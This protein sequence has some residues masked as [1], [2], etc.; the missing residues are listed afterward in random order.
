[1]AIIDLGTGEADKAKAAPVRG[2]VIDLESGDFA[3]PEAQGETFEQRAARLGAQ[4]GIALTP[5]QLGAI[6]RDETIDPAAPTLPSGRDFQPRQS[7]GEESGFGRGVEQGLLNIG[8]GILRG[9]GEI[10]AQLGDEGADQFLADLMQ[11]QSLERTQTE[12]ETADSPI[13]SFAGEVTGEIL[14]FPFGGAGGSLPTRLLSAAAAGGA[15]GALSAGGRGESGVDIA[16]EAAISGAIA[17]AA[18]GVSALLGARQAARQADVVGGVGADREAIESAA[19]S[20]ATGQRAAQETGIGLLP[21]QKTLDPFQAEVQ[22]FLGQNPEVSRKAFDTLKTQNREASEAVGSLLDAIAL[23]SSPATAPGRA[24]RAA[25]N[26]ID[27]VSAIRA[28]KASPIYKEAFA[29]GA[30]VDLLPVNNVIDDIISTL[31]EEGSAIKRKVLRAQ[32]LISGDPN[33]KQLHS[34]KLE[35]DEMLNAKGEGAVGSTT[36]RHLT[37]IQDTLVNEMNIASSLYDQAR[38]EFKR[39]SPAVDEIRDGVF[40]RIEALQDKDLKRV[41]S[42]IFD[43]TESNPEIAT[44]AIK[45]L[46][47]VEGGDEIVGGLIRTEIEKRLGRM[48][49]DLAEA[50]DTGGRK[51]ENLPQQLLNNVYGNAKQR[52]ML[53]SALKEV[54][55]KAAN[56]AKW[57]EEGLTRASVGRPGG[58]QT[59]VRNLITQQIRGASLAVRDFFRK[60]IESAVGLGEEAHFNS[61]VRA[62]GDALYNPDWS[63]DMDKIRKLDPN[64]QKA[65]SKFENLLNQIERAN[66]ATGVSSQAA[67]ATA[68]TE[69]NEE[70]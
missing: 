23:P 34:A 4:P 44:N 5:Q 49:V 16:K 14:G 9:I 15:G 30:D 3:E 50:A 45:S 26:I 27:G 41:S 13:S 64:S 63:P 8:G 46:K 24:R 19:K 31:P 25:T 57:L 66:S 68:R 42:I 10:R 35:I 60:P 29:E 20:V 37:E 7:T 11:S 55:P 33:L 54:N 40:G 39:L 6:E 36:R 32:R 38:E 2:R 52:K 58:S 56:N 1:M 69:L 28:E 62:L 47:N 59:G 53:F 70:Q 61:K 65:A 67:A 43:P 17:P 21:A 18:E 51:L 12:E 48:R 22:S